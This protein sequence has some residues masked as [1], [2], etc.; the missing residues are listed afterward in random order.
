MKQQ[1]N[2]QI[3]SLI[4]PMCSG[5]TTIGH[6]L[7]THLQYLFTDLDAAI[8]LKMGQSITEL[9]TQKGE[10]FFRTIESEVLNECL[11]T[12]SQVLATGG[13]IVLRP[14][15]RRRLQHQ[16]LVIY[17]QTDLKE[18][19]ARAEIDA[20]QKPNAR[21]LL[22]EGAIAERLSQIVAE[23]KELYEMTAH[24]ILD[25]NSKT[26]AAIVA[27]IQLLLD[28]ESSSPLAPVIRGEG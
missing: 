6:A 16:S 25:T 11:Q 13:G 8:E 14:K 24:Y 5:K 18:L 19:I 2:T 12:T 27:E 23:R 22:A 1:P 20:A 10:N 17:L 7:A 26:M 21:P 15:N 9:F 28:N 4:G 3:I